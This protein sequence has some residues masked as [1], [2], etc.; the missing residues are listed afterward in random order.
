MAEPL[1]EPVH[2]DVAEKVETLTIDTY[3]WMTTNSEDAISAVGI[4]VALYFVFFGIRWGLGRL[5]GDDYPVTHWRG[6]TRR[7][8]KRTRSPFIAAFSAFL[9]TRV[10]ETPPILDRAV[11]IAFTI[12]FAIQGALW[13]REILLALV[14]RRAADSEAPGDFDSAINIIRVMVNVI[15]WAL[16]AILILDNLGVNVTALVA[17]LGVGG[18]AIGL[19]AQG[20]FGD[21]FAALAILFDRPF[22]V[23]DVIS[24]GTNVGTVEAIGLKTT[25]VRALSGE[26]LIISNAKLLD[27][28]I[29]NLR[30]ITE[31]RV[32]FTIGVI[33]QTSPDKLEA[34][35]G[36]I[37]K[38]IRARPICRFDRVFFIQFSQS[39]LDFE[40]VYNVEDAD[41]QVMMAERQAIGLAIIRR[42][43]ELDI[44]FAYPTQTTFTALPDGTMVDPRPAFEVP[45]PKPA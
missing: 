40:I 2:K 34:I 12:A 27:Q 21:L 18:I 44:Q 5:L 35:P 25:R 38:I 41:L 29:S 6:F 17:G 37:E 32:A 33:Y 14:D 11:A 10:F 15:V 36:E 7:I 28:Q 22:K 13:L 9:V 4:A 31:R 24:Y 42:F 3:G 43:A 30:R 1:K 39:S 26:Q 23:G 8:V 16:A 45:P 19:A 20:I